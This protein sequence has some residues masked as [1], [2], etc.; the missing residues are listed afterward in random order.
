MDVGSN[1]KSALMGY[2]EQIETI[3]ASLS[4][5]KAKRVAIR[6]E[7]DAEGVSFNHIVKLKR[8]D[9]GDLREDLKKLQTAATYLGIELPVGQFEKADVS[10]NEEVQELVVERA[11]ETVDI[12]S[13]IEDL[14]EQ[15]KEILKAAKA[16]GF[17]PD[18]IKLVVKM[19]AKPKSV[20]KLLDKSSVVQVYWD[21]IGPKAA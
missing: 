1:S 8:S 14:Q 6:E 2:V 15:T 21:A 12:L 17:S 3:N 9:P 19:R 5:L 11:A 20:Q 7:L 4:H 13:E 10:D 18:G 16:E